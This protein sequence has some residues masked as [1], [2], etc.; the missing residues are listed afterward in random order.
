MRG[1]DPLPDAWAAYVGTPT[2]SDTKRS[3][4]VHSGLTPNLK[5]AHETLDAFLTGAYAPALPQIPM[6]DTGPE[7]VLQAIL[8]G[9][10]D[11]RANAVTRQTLTQFYELQSV[12]MRTYVQAELVPV[13]HGI[14]AVETS[15]G[16]L[17]ARMSAANISEARPE[18]HDPARRRI[19][20]IGFDQQTSFDERIGCMDSFMKRHFPDLRPLCVN[21]FPDKTGRPSVNG[22]V[23]MC[24]PQQARFVTDGVRAQN[25]KL[26]S[27]TNVKIKPALTDVDKNR[28]W[29]LKTAEELVKASPK[30]QGKLVSVQKGDRT[31]VIRGVYVDGIAVFTQ[32]QR[33]AKGGIVLSEFGDLKLPS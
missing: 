9:V 22:F 10:N 29:A 24:S 30:S 21:L 1:P 18:P 8:Q 20:F 17:E 15:V 6:P 3:R 5:A 7:S 12:E 32:V 28:N 33:Y 2:Q 4:T 26:D 13:H 16:Q 31:G 19:A 14:R 23:E 25:L 11:L 27:H